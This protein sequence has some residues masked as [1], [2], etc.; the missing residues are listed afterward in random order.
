VIDTWSK[1]PGN[2]ADAGISYAAF[3]AFTA[4]VC[5]VGWRTVNVRVHGAMAV[6]ML[7]WQIAGFAVYMP[8]LG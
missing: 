6:V 4:A 2:L 8:R 5:V 7:A 1:G 3:V